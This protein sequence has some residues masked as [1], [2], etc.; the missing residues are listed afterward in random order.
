[1]RVEIRDLEAHGRERRLEQRNQP[2]FVDCLPHP[3]P[4]PACILRKQKM[5]L[6]PIQVVPALL[7]MR[8]PDARGGLNKKPQPGLPI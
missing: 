7:S 5:G 6:R 4:Y 8:S 3:T 1:M 2:L